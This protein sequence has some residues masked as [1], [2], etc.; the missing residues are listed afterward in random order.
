MTSDPAH[1]PTVGASEL[2]RL[3]VFDLSLDCGHIVTLAID[4]WYPES[5]ACCDRLGGTDFHGEYVPFS[6][7]VEYANLLSETYEIRRHGAPREPAEILARRPRIDDPHPPHH[8]WTWGTAG[9]FPAR[10][11]ATAVIG[12]PATP[13]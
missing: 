11:G 7:N 10:V 8:R 12:R 9:R 1:P 2:E 4:G 13:A 5:V 6:S 3:C